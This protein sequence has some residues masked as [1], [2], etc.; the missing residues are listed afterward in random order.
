MLLIITILLLVYKYFDLK[1][2]LFVIPCY[3][4]SFRIKFYI[5]M[6]KIQYRILHSEYVH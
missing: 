5:A 4:S 2:F 3:H 1:K 6:N